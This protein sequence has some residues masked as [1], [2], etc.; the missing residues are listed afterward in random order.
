VLVYNDNGGAEIQAI[1][2]YQGRLYI[3]PLFGTDK[4]IKGADAH[5]F[6][7]DVPHPPRGAYEEYFSACTI[8]Y[9]KTDQKMTATVY[10]CRRSD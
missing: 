2:K 5:Y 7:L 4:N 10:D 6:E 1:G 3:A 8:I 9:K